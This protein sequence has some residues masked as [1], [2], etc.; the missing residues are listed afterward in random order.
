MALLSVVHKAGLKAGL[1]S[2]NNSLVDIALALLAPGG[3]DIEVDQSLTVDDGNT[4]LFRVR[5]VKQHSFHADI[6]QTPPSP[7][8]SSRLSGGNADLI[9]AKERLRMGQR[10]P[11]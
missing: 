7:A 4:Q 5:G 2:S 9:S 11:F 1:Y 10:G 3:F 8:R 6:S